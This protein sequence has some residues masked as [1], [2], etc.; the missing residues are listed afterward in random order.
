VLPISAAGFVPSAS[1]FPTALVNDSSGYIWFTDIVNNRIYR[2]TP[3]STLNQTTTTALKWQLPLTLNNTRG[4]AHIIV[5]DANT[6]VWFTDYSS[7]QISSL[8]WV[9]NLLTDYSLPA[10]DNIHP[11]DLV[12]DTKSHE[13]WFT[14]LNTSKFVNLN[15]LTGVLSIYNM[16]VTGAVGQLVPT[17]LAEIKA[18]SSKGVF[19]MTDWVLDNLYA[20]NF[21]TPL[22]GVVYPQVAGGLTLGLALDRVSN[23]WVTEPVKDFVNEQLANSSYKSH[24]TISPSS[25]D[26][27]QSQ[28]TINP[29]LVQIKIER[30]PV[31]PIEVGV[32][33]VIRADPLEIWGVPSA[34]SWPWGVAIDN[35]NNPWFTEYVG[36]Q[37]G[38]VYPSA[39]K[40]TE[41]TVPTANSHPLYITV[42][43]V[44][45]KAPVNHI[46]FTEFTGGKVGELFN[47]TYID[48]RVAP[49]LPPQY[50]P[51]SPGSIRWTVE[52]GAQ[53]WTDAPNNGYNS[54][55]H[56]IPQRGVVNHLYA[57]VRNM[58]F[59][60]ATNV[61]VSFYWHNASIA[62]AEFVPLPP[63]TPSATYWAYIGSTVIPALP[64]GVSMDVYVDFTI[65]STVP[66]HF[67]V[68][69]QA[70]AAGDINLYD[71]V[72][73][74]NFEIQ[75]IIAGTP[76][77]IYVP[78]WAT[79]FMNKSGDMRIALSN[80]PDGWMA[81]IE[82]N[83]FIMA[84]GESR[85]LNLTIQVPA[86]AQPG[87]HAMI[88]VTGFIDGMMTGAFWLEVNVMSQA[89]PGAGPVFSFFDVFF[90]LGGIAVGAIVMF[91]VNS[92]RRGTGGLTMKAQKADKKR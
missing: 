47:G 82:P 32:T 49:P 69:A 63:G 68:G 24:A 59:S 91:G 70:N 7:M 64:S 89:G 52:P 79:N 50:P 85:L 19:Y 5:D 26:S 71:N 37:I 22:A 45:S 72:A 29:Q 57:T 81:D 54:A 84:S 56:D 46:W 21:T 8:N 92:R 9:T 10:T 44:G 78:I 65:T 18:N 83:G 20:L 60:T 53:I 4:P 74:R 28:K 12:M 33:P 38:V 76:T 43:L 17:Y 75:N 1:N 11:W 34:P 73:Y 36:N 87:M 2:L 25:K 42:Q 61:N 67:C 15:P 23:V 48:V 80:V 39:S 51:P 86:S 58:G 90:L 30:T 31:R 88:M 40:I 66:D 35:S 77:T 55:D 14:A 41:Y 62:F 13:I 16:Q 27:V 3:A 6:R